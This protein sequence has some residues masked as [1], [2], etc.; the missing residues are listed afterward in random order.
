MEAQA[1]EMDS[2]DTRLRNCRI[3]RTLSCNFADFLPAAKLAGLQ[4]DYIGFNTGNGEK[5]SNS[6]AEP[7]QLLGCGLV[8]FISGVE[9][10]VVT[11]YTL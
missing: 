8:P 5:L 3:E 11:L 2:P 4:G 7:G 1:T 10:Y 6:Q 9:F